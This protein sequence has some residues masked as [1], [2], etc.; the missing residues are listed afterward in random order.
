MDHSQPHCVYAGPIS[1][2]G[3]FADIVFESLLSRERSLQERNGGCCTGTDGFARKSVSAAVFRNTIYNVLVTN[4][5]K[6]MNLK[7]MADLAIAGA[8]GKKRRLERGHFP[9]VILKVAGQVELP[10]FDVAQRIVSSGEVSIP[11]PVQVCWMSPQWYESPCVQTAIADQLYEMRKLCKRFRAT[12]SLAAALLT[13]SNEGGVPLFPQEALTL[14]IAAAE[15]REGK[16]MCLRS[17]AYIL[18]HVVSFAIPGAQIYSNDVLGKRLK[19]GLAALKNLLTVLEARVSQPERSTQAEIL[20]IDP[21]YFE[22]F[23][24]SPQTTR[25]REGRRNYAKLAL[26][27]LEMHESTSS[28]QVTP[29]STAHPGSAAPLTPESAASSN[30]R[31]ATPH[32]KIS[33]R[34]VVR[35]VRLDNGIRRTL[36]ESDSSSVSGGH[37]TLCRGADEV[38]KSTY[39]AIALFFAGIYIVLLAAML[40]RVDFGADGIVHELLHPVNSFGAP[41]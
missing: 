30:L 5:P 17:F 22:T 1:L 34:G 3:R 10:A 29:R 31:I 26:R 24:S 23:L 32:P 11:I 16:E 18:T 38:S 15:I 2:A 14:V 20:R 12:S 40:R 41:I 35:R 21:P 6:A 25:L 37:V 8:S 36:S 13:L 4:V 28:R 27:S 33:Q 7:R 9:L 19:S 39:A